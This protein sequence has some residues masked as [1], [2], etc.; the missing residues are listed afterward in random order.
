MAKIVIAELEFQDGRRYR[1]RTTALFFSI[2]FLTAGFA[3][4]FA[5][6]VSW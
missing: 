5:L 2:I 6:G 1:F 3:L 4:G